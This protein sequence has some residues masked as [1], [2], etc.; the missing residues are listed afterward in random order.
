MRT[1][2]SPSSPKPVP[3]ATA[4]WACCDQLLGELDRAEVAERG[5][6]RRPREHARA[7]HRDVP[8][9]A[10]E[11]FDQHVAAVFVEGARRRDAVLRAVERRH[12]RRL[13]R[14]ER[15]IIEVRL[16]PR[17][18]GD[19]LRIADREADPPAGHRIGLAHAGELDRDVL[20]ARHLQDRRRRHVVEIDLGIG[21]VADD[22]DAVAFGE[23]DDAFVEAEVDRLGGRVRRIAHDE[24]RRLWHGIAHRMFELV[25]QVGTRRGGD[26]AD[27]AAGDDEAEHVDRVRRVRRED[28][29]AGRGD[30]LGE[31]GQ[32]LLRAERD[33]DLAL[34]IDL[35]AEAARVIGG[36]RLAQ[37]RDA[38]RRRIAVGVGLG[39]DLGELGDDVR[40]R[41]AVGVAHA[42][43]D[44][45][46]AA[47]A[48]RRLHRVDFG[49]DVRRQAADTVEFVG[50]G[51]PQ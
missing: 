9:G 18:R 11:A 24:H 2:P 1:K 39:R 32:P 7:R 45:V 22:P 20:R 38:A 42:E 33:D 50:H 23:G 49:E 25:E 41:R 40:R 13:D 3:G 26:A 8:A 29:V 47:R 27:G 46:L 35:D 36:L 37:P 34:G 4:R 14:R 48:C 28:D 15:A 19:E 17:Q 10:G 51:D 12:R 16:D 43:V 6:D 5:R 44:D 21:E 30:R 31:V